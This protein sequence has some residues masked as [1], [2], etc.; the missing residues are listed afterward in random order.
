MK[1]T[2]PRVVKSRLGKTSL[3][4]KSIVTNDEG[5]IFGSE[6]AQSKAKWSLVDGIAETSDHVFIAVD[7][8]Y[9]IVI[10]KDMVDSS[11]LANFLDL[12]R[13]RAIING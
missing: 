12:L 13:S 10:P 3:G 7:G 8:T 9:S 11:N 4:S 5:I 2:L 6:D 1:R